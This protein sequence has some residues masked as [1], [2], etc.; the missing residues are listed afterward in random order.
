MTSAIRAPLPVAIDFA[1]VRPVV[2]QG[3]QRD[4]RLRVLHIL[5][6]V[7]AFLTNEDVLKSVLLSLGH[8]VSADLLRTELLWLQEQGLIELRQTGDLYIARLLSRG[9]DVARGAAQQP[10]IASPME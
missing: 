4:R 10:G 5:S 1:A 7:P 3:L 6:E 9:Q 8:A 2:A